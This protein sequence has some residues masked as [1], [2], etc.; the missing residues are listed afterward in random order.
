MDK[1]L[2][3]ICKILDVP[4]HGIGITDEID[5]DGVPICEPYERTDADVLIQIINKLLKKLNQD[6][7]W[8]AKR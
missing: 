2:K 3:E 4:T 8:G 7:D 1:K 6:T 5:E